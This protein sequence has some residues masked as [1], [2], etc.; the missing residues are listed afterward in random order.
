MQSIIL[1]ILIDKRYD[2]LMAIEKQLTIIFSIL[3]FFT[4]SL[5]QK[6]QFPRTGVFSISIYE[7]YR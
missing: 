6:L 2:D 1:F 4:H 7:P 3:G 5:K